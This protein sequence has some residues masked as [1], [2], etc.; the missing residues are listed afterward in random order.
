M[1]S[2]FRRDKFQNAFQG[3]PSWPK[4]RREVA[5]NYAYSKDTVEVAHILMLTE[6]LPISSV[7]TS[8]QMFAFKSFTF[9]IVNL[10]RI[11]MQYINAEGLL[12]SLEKALLGECSAFSVHQ[13]LKKPLRR[14]QFHLFT[15]RESYTL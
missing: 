1:K 8:Q 5:M 9:A 7:L 13:S 6:T 2:V 11:W 12:I 10:Y 14:E 4:H 15:E 3:R